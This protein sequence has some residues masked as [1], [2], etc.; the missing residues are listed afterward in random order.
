MAGSDLQA[1]ADVRAVDARRWEDVRE[2]FAAVRPAAV[3]HLANHVNARVAEPQ[4]ILAENAAMNA[5]VAEAARLAG[6][7]RLVFASSVQVFTGERTTTEPD[8][9]SELAYLPLDGELPP[10]LS[11]AYAASKAAGEDL[12]RHYARSGEMTCVALRLPWLMNERRVREID[13]K[14]AD[15]AFTWLTYA[16]AAQLALAALTAPL[17]GYRCY[18]AASELPWAAEPVEELRRRFFPGVPVRGALP[19]RSFVDNSAA[20]RELGWRPTA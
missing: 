16:D 18:F 15:E 4:V 19:L 5:H 11:N 12:L 8:Q 2:V 7:A 1:T 20:L 17:S 3:L 6:A 10:L 13:V 14:R 9:P